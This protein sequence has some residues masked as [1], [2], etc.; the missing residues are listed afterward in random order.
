MKDSPTSKKK[1]NPIALS[2]WIGYSLISANLLDMEG[3]KWTKLLK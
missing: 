3:K 2:Y 1:A